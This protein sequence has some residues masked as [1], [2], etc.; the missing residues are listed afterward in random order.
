MKTDLLNAR[1]L[2]YPNL[3]DLKYEWYEILED[4]DEDIEEENE[5][6]PFMFSK[7]KLHHSFLEDV[8]NLFLFTG[9]ELVKKEVY[10]VIN[11]GGESERRLFAKLKNELGEKI[12]IITWPEPSIFR[13][14]H[15]E[16]PV[17][18]EVLMYYSSFV[19]YE[20]R[21][22]I[23]H[24]SF[25]EISELFYLRSE[26]LLERE[27]ENIRKYESIYEKQPPYIL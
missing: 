13:V 21:K 2:P 9:Y 5:P 4:E 8:L 6:F 26:F 19:F 3:E 12:Y 1:N 18:L 22:R 25:D 15:K 7:G 14:I 10:E 20:D 16:Y 11:E 24:L 27:I 17:E 23:R